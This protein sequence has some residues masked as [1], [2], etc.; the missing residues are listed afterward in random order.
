M[1]KNAHATSRRFSM[2]MLADLY[3]A[4]FYQLTKQP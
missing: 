3:S 2:D 4:L 1:V